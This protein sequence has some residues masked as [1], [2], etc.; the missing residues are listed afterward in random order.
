MYYVYI[1]RCEDGSLYTGSA[2]D[3]KKRVREHFTKST[4][5]AKYTRSHP[6]KEVAAVWRCDEKS[7][8]GKVEYFIKTLTKKEKENLIKNNEAPLKIIERLEGGNLS[9]L[10]SEELC[11]IMKCSFS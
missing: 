1:L 9:R 5:S 3:I 4:K 11:E 8:G 10:T 6:P 7:Y 2:R